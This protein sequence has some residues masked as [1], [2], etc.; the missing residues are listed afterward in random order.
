VVTGL[1]CAFALVANAAEAPPD[2]CVKAMKDLALFARDMRE[3]GAEQ[4]L[5]QA[6]R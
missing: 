4:D 2:D 5:A 6:S 1:V 3:P